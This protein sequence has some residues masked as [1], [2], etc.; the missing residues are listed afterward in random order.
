M[1]LILNTFYGYL[2]FIHENKYIK[3]KK[4]IHNNEYQE[5]SLANRKMRGGEAIATRAINVLS[6][7][8]PGNCVK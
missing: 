6:N 1:H 7:C 8:I 5:L 4:N 2:Q 3:I